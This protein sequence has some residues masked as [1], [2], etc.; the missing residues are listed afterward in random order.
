MKKEE[1]AAE[2][3]FVFILPSLKNPPFV[4]WCCGTVARCWQP[5]FR[6]VRRR[7][8]GKMKY[9]EWKDNGQ[10]KVVCT[11]GRYRCK[12]IRFTSAK[13]NFFSPENTDKKKRKKNRHAAIIIFSLLAKARALEFPTKIRKKY[14]FSFSS[15]SRSSIPHISAVTTYLLLHPFPDLHIWA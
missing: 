15:P 4:P 3:P 14:F 6:L 8:N 1:W 13:K 9:I 10:S 12:P 5:P 11:N 7:G 2:R